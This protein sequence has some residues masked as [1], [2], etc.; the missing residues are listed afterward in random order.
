V[1]DSGSGNEDN[2]QL[3]APTFTRDTTVMISHWLIV[4]IGKRSTEN[5]FKTGYRSRFETYFGKSKLKKVLTL[6]KSYIS[7]V[8]KSLKSYIKGTYMADHI[9]FLGG[10][11]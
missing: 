4:L 5:P 11:S 8:P 2:E 9:L 1:W 10:Y 6:L 7:E 3:P